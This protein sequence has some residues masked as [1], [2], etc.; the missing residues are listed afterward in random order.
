MTAVDYVVS[1]TGESR[2][3]KNVMVLN[4]CMGLAAFIV[5]ALC[6][7]LNGDSLFPKNDPK[8]K[9]GP[10]T[11]FVVAVAEVAFTNTIASPFGY[12][13]LA[14]ITY[15]ML[16]LGKVS[17]QLFIAHSKTLIC[18]YFLCCSS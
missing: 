10:K 14:Y 9:D 1:N 11:T 16:V 18:V 12:A 17:A 15:P 3:F 7:T 6:V 13:A 2:R 8:Q 4:L 5:G